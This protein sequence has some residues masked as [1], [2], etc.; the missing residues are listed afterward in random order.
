[1]CIVYFLVSKIQIKKLI[2]IFKSTYVC[3]CMFSFLNTKSIE[4]SQ[5][6]MKFPV[7][8]YNFE[9][10]LYKCI[11]KNTELGSPSYIP[12]YDFMSNPTKQKI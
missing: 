10:F 5:N 9:R 11:I 12:S 3:K 8:N 7:I 6:S 1:M 2:D 4:N